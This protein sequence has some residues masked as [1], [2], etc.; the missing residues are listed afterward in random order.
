[1]ELH[2]QQT[3]FLW[4]ETK[5]VRSVPFYWRHVNRSDVGGQYIYV[6]Y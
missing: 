6:V 2:G 5:Q 4:F 1:M 3:L